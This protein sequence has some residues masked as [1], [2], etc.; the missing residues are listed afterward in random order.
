MPRP[1]RQ[2]TMIEEAVIRQCWE[3]TGTV[4]G[5]RWTHQMMMGRVH[6]ISWDTARRWLDQLGI[7][8]DP[9]KGKE[10]PGD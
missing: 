1:K 5:F 6:A 8:D 9:T 2:F 3:R 4:E 7:R 10:Q